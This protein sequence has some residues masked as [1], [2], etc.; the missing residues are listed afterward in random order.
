MNNV[1]NIRE[2]LQLSQKEFG[3]AIG[4]TQGAVGH[5]ETGVNEPS[6]TNAKK[7]KA[8][9]ADRG[10]NISLDQI[11]GLAPLPKRVIKINEQLKGD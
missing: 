8:I 11:H 2:F 4:C 7:I 6:V 1:K 9:A 10:L 3:L 5:Y